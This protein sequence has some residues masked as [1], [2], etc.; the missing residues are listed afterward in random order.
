MV[1]LHKGKDIFSGQP[2]SVHSIRSKLAT[3]I[4]SQI[5]QNWCLPYSTTFSVVIEHP[6][7][8]VPKNVFWRLSNN[9]PD[10]TFEFDGA[11]TFIVFFCGFLVSV[12]NHFDFGYCKY[13][14]MYF[15][16]F[17]IHI[18]ICMHDNG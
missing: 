13:K 8:M 3:L 7:L 9:L 17:L 18:Q 14:K 2:F 1:K 5:G 16:Y 11:A 4:A 15:E 6:V 12:I 10:N